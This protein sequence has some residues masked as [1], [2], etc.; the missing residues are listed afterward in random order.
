MVHSR[1]RYIVGWMPRVKGG[2]PGKPSHSP[3][4]QSFRSSAVYRRSIGRLL[5]VVNSAARSGRLVSAGRRV[6]SSQSR[7]VREL[8][9]V[10][11]P[12]FLGLVTGALLLL[13]DLLGD[14]QP[15]D[16]GRSL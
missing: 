14:H 9:V 1:P 4:S 3:G 12:P 2:S 8:R 11:R 13:Q 15:L 6:V 5:T 16:L 7:R 10:D